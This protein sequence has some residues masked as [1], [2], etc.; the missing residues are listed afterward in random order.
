MPLTD[1]LGV[2]VVERLGLHDDPRVPSR[3]ADGLFEM[4]LSHLADDQ[5][6]LSVPQNLENKALFLRISETLAE[7]LGERVQGVLSAPWPSWLPRLIKAAHFQR[8]TVITF[9]YDTLIECAV[10]TG[11]LPQTEPLHEF[12]ELETVFWTELTQNVPNWLPGSDRPNSPSMQTLRLLKLHGSLNWY[13]APGDEMGTSVVRRDL[14]GRFDTPIPYTE[15]ARRRELPGRVPFV[16]PPSASKSGYYR[17]LFVREIWQQAHQALEA[18]EHVVVIGYSLPLTDL[19]V[20]DMLRDALVGSESH[21]TIVDPSADQVRQR[22]EHLGVAS[23][24][25]TLPGAGPDGPVAGFVNDWVRTIGSDVLRA[26]RD[27]QGEEREDPLL[28]VWT[29]QGVSAVIGLGEDQGAHV[30]RVEVL[31]QVGMATR[32]RGSYD[33]GRLPTLREVVSPPATGPLMVEL[34]DGSR[35]TVIGLDRAAFNTGYGRGHWH[36]L[37]TDGSFAAAGQGAS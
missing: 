1:E 13:W 5:P 14:P 29:P 16:V 33:R 36:V 35:Q 19:T 20:V 28:V 18:A 34:P 26:L 24:R 27:V 21:V 32:G 10:A 25:I 31:G 9:N 23:D 4:W 3:F 2:A 8:S 30:L 17:N 22:L 15:E 7:A 11:L 12:M 37:Y 6:F